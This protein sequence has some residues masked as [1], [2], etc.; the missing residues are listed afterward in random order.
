MLDKQKNKMMSRVKSA[1][2]KVFLFDGSPGI[3]KGDTGY[4]LRAIRAVYIKEGGAVV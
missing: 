3:K 2:I 4:Y 1:K